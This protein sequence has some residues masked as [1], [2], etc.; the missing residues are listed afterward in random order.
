MIA[1]IRILFWIGVLMLFV[2]YLG[3][4][5]GIRAILTV[6][7]GALVIW[8]S[9]RLRRQ[10]KELRFRLRR[11]EEPTSAPEVSTDTK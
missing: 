8:L 6:A 4:R 3:I 10:Y 1:K 2:P 9:L 5:S 7:L 11:F